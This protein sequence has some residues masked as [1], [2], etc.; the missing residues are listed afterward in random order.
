MDDPVEAESL[1][2]F[3]D[4]GDTV[5]GRGEDDMGGGLAHLRQRCGYE[6]GP[7]AGREGPALREDR[8]WVGWM[9]QDSSASSART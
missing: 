4:Q 1:Y 3:R 2:R 8:P 7:R 9:T 6:A 5:T